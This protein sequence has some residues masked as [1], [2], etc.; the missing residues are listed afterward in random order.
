MDPSSSVNRPSVESSNDG[1]DTSNTTSTSQSRVTATWETMK[2]GF[3]SIKT[4]I[5]AKKFLY[6]RESDENNLKESPEA[7]K[8]E[9]LDEIFDNLK[10]PA[11]DRRKYSSHIDFDDYGMDIDKQIPR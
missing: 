5:E 8:T 1:G 7:S 3:Q 10:R 2:T 4:N 6:L 11:R 9:S